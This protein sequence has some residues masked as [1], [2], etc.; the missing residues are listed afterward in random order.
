MNS[1]RRCIGNFGARI[2]GTLKDAKI[3]RESRRVK[4]RYVGA[5]TGL[6]VTVEK[7]RVKCVSFH[8][9]SERFAIEVAAN[10]GVPWVVEL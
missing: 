2:G 4:R 6:G 9:H 1:G 3:V 7:S 5:V 8:R 10:L